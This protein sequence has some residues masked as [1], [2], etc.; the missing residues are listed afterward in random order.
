MKII[1]FTYEICQT[2]KSEYHMYSLIYR[3]HESRLG[4]RPVRG[5]RER[6]DGDGVNY[7]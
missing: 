5:E 3:R 6:K 7:D 4:G 1:M 2:Q